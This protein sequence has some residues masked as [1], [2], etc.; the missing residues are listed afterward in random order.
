M[1]VEPSFDRSRDV[2]RQ[3]EIERIGRDTVYDQ[4]R[5]QILHD[6]AYRQWD[7]CP[8]SQS[9]DR[10]EHQDIMEIGRERQQEIRDGE[11]RG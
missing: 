4:L 8:R 6:E 1:V 2:E 3:L 9:A 11:N 7:E 5:R 10:L